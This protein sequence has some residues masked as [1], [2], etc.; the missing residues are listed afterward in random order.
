MA[1]VQPQ[2]GQGTESAGIFD[3]YLQ[4]V[5]EEQREI[6]TGYLKDAEKHVNERVQKASELEK[7]FGPYQELGLNQYQPEQLQQLLGWYEQV[8]QSEDAFKNWLTDAAKEAGLTLA[9]AEEVAEEAE[10]HDLTRKEAEELA[11]QRAQEMVAPLE[12]RQAEW[13]EQRM[14]DDIESGI[15]KELR[16]VETKD[17]VS[18][19]DEEKAEIIDL[20]LHHEGD[21]WIEY[22]YDRY[23]KIYTAGQRL[24]VE[25][26]LAQP[27]SPMTTG[28]HE[29][30]KPTTD[31]DEAKAQALEVL[32]HRR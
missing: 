2:E 8:S 4:S 22:G 30:F 23:K 28:G 10:E 25:Q 5:P 15:L 3:A 1:D 27:Q 7:T 12:Q 16:D 20:G 21:N 31:W 9:Q 32:R 11:T 19:T 6:A 13:E 29:A 24:F 17:G 14:V 26:K 18:L